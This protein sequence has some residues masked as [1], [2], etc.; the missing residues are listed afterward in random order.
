[1][2]HTEVFGFIQRGILA[3]GLM[4]PDIETHAQ[5]KAPKA[6][7]DV[8]LFNSKGERV[9]MQMFEG[10][11]IFM[12]IWATWCA[13]CIAEM[14]GINALY[15]KVK[16]EDIVFVMLSI[17]DRF[18]KAVA[19]KEQKGFDFEVYRLDGKLPQMYATQS[20][21]TTYVIDSE[22]NLVLDHKGM[23]NYNSDE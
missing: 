13:P 10:K 5:K 19:F 18:E 3:T 2:L 16:N 14:P 22:G 7:L 15:Q 11:V 23:A 9:N 21:P 12:N 8:P 17:D 4:T 6:N 1:G 20:I